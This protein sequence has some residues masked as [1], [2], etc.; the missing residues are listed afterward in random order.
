MYYAT[1]NSKF[2]HLETLAVVKV[3]E[4]NENVNITPKGISTLQKAED[5]TRNSDI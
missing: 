3:I 5:T 1:R 2:K 4:I